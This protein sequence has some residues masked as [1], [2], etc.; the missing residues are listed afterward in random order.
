MAKIIITTR[1]MLTPALA[2]AIDKA[3]IL[4]TVALVFFSGAA[5]TNGTRA[6]DA[7]YDGMAS[8][9]EAMCEDAST[10]MEM[11]VCS[12][13]RYEAADSVLRSVYQS[14][15][16]TIADTGFGS[17]LEG[18]WR[19]GLRKAQRLWEQTRKADCGLVS[20]FEWRG[21]TG[22]TGAEYECLATVTEQRA[23]LLR[24]RYL[25]G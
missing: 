13:R 10:V 16:G 2:S 3:V 19:E 24:S 1:A 6:Q 11:N 15:L 20:A 12:R 21:G 9:W 8:S 17:E 14:A 5:I 4:V 7:G 25:D 18:Q 22:A 23:A